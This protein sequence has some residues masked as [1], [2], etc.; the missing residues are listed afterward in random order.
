MRKLLFHFIYLC[1][2]QSLSAQNFMSLP[3]LDGDLDFWYDTVVQD[4]QVPLLQGTFYFKDDN[5]SVTHKQNPFYNETWDP[6]GVIHF[7]GRPFGPIQLIYNSLEDIVLIW[8]WDVTLRDPKSLL[9]DQA[10]VDSFRVH[11][12]KFVN[13][14]LAKIG[15]RGFYR[16]VMQG[17]RVACF[18]KEVKTIRL[19]GTA[20]EYKKKTL[21]S[22]TY[23]DQVY[24]CKTVSSLNKIFPDHK[25]QVRQHLRSNSY[26]FLSDKEFRL[27]FT[28]N[29]LD[30]ILP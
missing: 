11:N 13:Y 8:S 14:K 7:D 24:D 15:K 3:E 4:I 23:R 19:D 12:D 22:V 18:A 9:V 5:K 27:Q 28:L 16:V 17:N 26:V 6:S 20:Y 29:Y 2:L 1:S 10:R 25:K 21:Y 30:T